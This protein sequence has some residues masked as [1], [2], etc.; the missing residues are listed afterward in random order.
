M[1]VIGRTVTVRCRVL[2]GVIGAVFLDHKSKC[3]DTKYDFYCSLFEIV[4]CFLPYIV[5]FSKDVPKEGKMIKFCIH[6]TF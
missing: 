4:Q 5:S 6:N 1:L 2:D 3:Y